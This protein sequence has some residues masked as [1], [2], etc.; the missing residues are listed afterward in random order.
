[1]VAFTSLQMTNM[2]SVQSGGNT[3]YVS[4][5]GTLPGYPTDEGYGFYPHVIVIDAGDTVVWTV[6][7]AQEHTVSFFSSQPSFNGN[8]L[9]S[10]FPIPCSPNAPNVHNGT[11]TDSETPPLLLLLVAC[12]MFNSYSRSQKARGHFIL[13]IQHN[14]K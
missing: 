4:I 8:S 10:L 11:A 12:A 1:M 13:K 7:T 9:Q 2:A 5:G 14:P 3:W 6:V